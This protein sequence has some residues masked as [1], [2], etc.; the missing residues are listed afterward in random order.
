MSP[1]H[2][3]MLGGP[4][5]FNRIKAHFVYYRFCIC[6]CVVVINLTNLELVKIMLRSIF[7]PNIPDR[8]TS[9]ISMN[10]VR[11]SRQK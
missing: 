6:V 5:N 1:Y 8:L 4:S 11:V 7:P 2:V 10:F 3:T 9:I